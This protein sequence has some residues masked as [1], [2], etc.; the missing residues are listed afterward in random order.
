[1]LEV[2]RRLDVRS[3]TAINVIRTGRDLVL[4]AKSHEPVI[5]AIVAGKAAAARRAVQAHVRSFRP[6][7][8]HADRG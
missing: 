8:P 2:W 6:P 7:L 4:V 1:L 3:R 5:R